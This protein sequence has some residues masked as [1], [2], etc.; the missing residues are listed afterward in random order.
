VIKFA[1]KCAN[2][3]LKF[4]VLI[5]GEIEQKIL[6]AMATFALAKRVW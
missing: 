1:K 6:H 3:S 4:G 2:V 5:L